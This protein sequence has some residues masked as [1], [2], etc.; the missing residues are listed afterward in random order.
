MQFRVPQFIEVESKVIGPFSFREFV[1][2]AGGIGF[3]VMLW[4]WVSPLVAIVVGLPIAGLGAALAFWKPY[5]MPFEKLLEAAFW[6]AT[7]RHI[8]I[9]KKPAPKASAPSSQENDVAA[10][11]IPY[12]QTT[13]PSRL[14]EL[15]FQLDIQRRQRPKKERLEVKER[16]GLQV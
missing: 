12:F 11:P 6:Y 3:V 2:L 1:F 15:A 9:W 7:S 14:R 4:L 5:G 13:K 10:R 16:L 8:Y